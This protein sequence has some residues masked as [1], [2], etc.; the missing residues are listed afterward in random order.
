FRQCTAHTPYYHTESDKTSAA[1]NPIPAHYLRPDHNPNRPP[2]PRIAH[3]QAPARQILRNLR[4]LP[5]TP[6]HNPP[7]PPHTLTHARRH[8]RT[9]RTVRTLPARVRAE[10]SRSPLPHR[11][12]DLPTTL[13]ARHA[14]SIQ[15][16]LRKE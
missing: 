14:P 15:H 2:P 11:H 12:R 7:H 3:A 6:T 8:P 16:V 13:F 9:P 5:P 10:P 4:H 1:H